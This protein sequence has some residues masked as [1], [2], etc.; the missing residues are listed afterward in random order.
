MYRD[1]Y[2]TYTATTDGTYYVSVQSYGGSD[3]G[4]YSLWMNIQPV[5]NTTGNGTFAYTLSEG[6]GAVQDTAAD[7]T[8]VSG[9]T[10]TVHFNVGYPDW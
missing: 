6:G 9:T 2:L 3:N 10:I 8:T 7:V 5:V 4:T 1:S